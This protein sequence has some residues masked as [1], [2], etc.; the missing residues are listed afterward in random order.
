MR[1]PHAPAESTPASGRFR[2]DTSRA[3]AALV[4]AADGSVDHATARGVGP[5]ELDVPLQRDLVNDGAA[6]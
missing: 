2:L 1:R 4:Q 6:V 3:G 5:G